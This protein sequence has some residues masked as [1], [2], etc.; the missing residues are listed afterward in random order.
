MEIT[1]YPFLIEM[2]ILLVDDEVALT[3]SLSQV[4]RREG[5]EVD[6]ATNGEQGEQLATTGDYNLLILDWMLPHRSGLECEMANWLPQFCF[7]LR[8]I[9]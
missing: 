9:P 2:K 7:S 8:K 3:E 1:H 5:Y 4:L 6:I